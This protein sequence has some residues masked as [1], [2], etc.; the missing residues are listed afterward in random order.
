MRRLK[1]SVFAPPRAR[2]WLAPLQQP[3]VG[4]ALTLLAVIWLA[5]WQQIETERIALERDVAQDTANLALVFEQNIARTLSEIDR[6]ALFLRHTYEQNP[7]AADWPAMV[8]ERYTVNEHTLQIAV[9]GAQGRLIATSYGPQPAPAIDLS[10]REHFRVHRDSNTDRLF[11]SK[12]LIGRATG[13]WSVQLTRRFNDARGAF[14]GVIVISLDP[15]HLSK[16]Y[17]SLTLGTGGGLALVG[18]DDIIRAGA[19]SFAGE[20]GRGIRSNLL[21]ER[22]AYSENGTEFFLEQNKGMRRV[23]ASRPVAGHSLF[24]LVAGRDVAQDATRLRMQQNYLIGAAVLSVIVVLSMLAA[25]SSRR[26]H[27][28]QINHFARNDALTEIANRVSFRDKLDALLSDPVGKSTFA[29]HLIDLDRF[30]AVNDTYGHPVGDKLLKAVADRL[31]SGVRA[32]DLVAR[33]GGD[34]FAVIQIEVGSESDAAALAGR[35]CAVVSQPYAIDG[36]RI[37]IGASIGIA[38]GGRD[39]ASAPG[40]LKAADLALYTAKSGGRGI[41]RFFKEEM[42]ATARARREIEESLRT[43]LDARQLELHYQP[44]VSLES[45]RPTGYEALLRWRHPE[46]GLIPPAVFVPVAEET[47]LIIPIGAWVIETAC[48]EIARRSSDLRLAV[49]LSPIQFNSPHLADTIRQALATSGLEARRLEVEITESTLMQRD[50]VTIGLLS[51]LRAMGVKIAMDDFGTGYSS[52]SYLHT[53]PIN[54][55]KIDRS[56]VKTLGENA[57]AAAI[58]GAITNLARALGMTTTAEGVETRAQLEQLAANGCTEVQGYYFSAPR[59]AD[60]ILP[61]LMSSGE[62]HALAA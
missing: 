47:G 30:K 16:T 21:P 49:N 61:P 27:E 40:L 4:F 7:S 55:I 13:R 33:L 20:L 18:S 24:V 5:V 11:V 32:G 42:G 52:L 6:V 59:P 9:I 46:R 22:A 48:R 54:C 50:N 53:Y 23:V 36:L 2:R 19:G 37:E 60:E 3:V 44:I 29:L 51:E 26:R 43:A 15:D 31:R 10:D 56:F 28:R 45:G 35:V 38:L 14:A 25:V 1:H 17:S 8:K 12:P 34:E 57:S 58:V 62:G 41:Y 39:G